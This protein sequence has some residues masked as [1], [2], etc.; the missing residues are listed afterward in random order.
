MARKY[1]KINEL[2]VDMKKYDYIINGTGGIGKTTLAKEVGERLTGSPEGTLIISLGLEP[3]PTHI[4][5]AFYT[6]APDWTALDEIKQDLIDNRQD[7][8][9]TVFI[10]FDSLD[11]L[12]RLAEDETVRVWN[13]QNPTEKVKSVSQAFKGFQKGENY[14]L[15]LVLELRQELRQAGYK[16]FDA[17]HTKEK[18]KNPWTFT[19]YLLCFYSFLLMSFHKLFTWCRVFCPRFIPNDVR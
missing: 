3:V 11:E 17:G 6:Y 9:N 8:K 15:K 5:N 10:T 1:G 14:A 4:N 18:G 13:K 12:F 7:Y 19:F 16:F 2:V